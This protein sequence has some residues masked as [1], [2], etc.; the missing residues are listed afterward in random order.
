MFHSIR[1]E[2]GTE[3]SQADILLA[4]LSAGGNEATFNPF[5]FQ[6]LL[7]RIDRELAGDI[8]GP[9]FDVRPYDC[10]PSDEAAFDL[11]DEIAADGRVRIDRSGP[12]RKSS[13][14]EA[15]LQEGQTIPRRMPCVAAQYL[16]KAS[17]WVLSLDSWD[18]VS[19]ICRHYPE[20]VVQGRIR[21]EAVRRAPAAQ[22]P[23]HPFLRGMAS[24][25]GI[26]DW[27]DASSPSLTHSDR[28]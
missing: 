3:L 8:A 10:G 25:T 22:R 18:L 6:T 4:A 19:A 11:A 20:M 21:Q 28:I 2:T 15:G 13:I 17:K 5:Q 9:H 26:P 24:A 14:T 16:V 23:M 7:F 27:E 1:G 12:Y